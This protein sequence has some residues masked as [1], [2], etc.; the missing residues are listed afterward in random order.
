MTIVTELR[1]GLKRSYAA[2]AEDGKLEA[3]FTKIVPEQMD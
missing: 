1:M 2:S 3:T